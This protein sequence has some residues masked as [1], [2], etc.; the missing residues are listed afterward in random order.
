MHT[1][2]ISLGGSLIVPNG[3]IDSEFL[4]KF[5]RFI[6]GR[7]RKGDRF[8][9]IT[10]G[11][12]VAREYQNAARDVTKLTRDDLD[13]LGIHATR[14]NAH[15]LRTIFRDIAHPVICTDPTEIAASSKYKVKIAA[16]WK[17]GWSTD[18]VATRIAKRLKAELV[19]NLSNVDYVYETDPRKDKNAKKLDA[20]SWKDFR[21]I[22]G[23]KWDPGL[24]APFDPVAS[25]LAHHSG[26]P[27]VVANGK[28]IKNIGA[29]LRGGKFK[30]TKIS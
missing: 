2:V 16:G 3:H 19:I 13:W 18:Y 8:V 26:I 21:K 28:D 29:I 20:I 6:A 11:G 27:V 12:G 24:S 10:G 4:K 22:V 1:Y 5:K 23:N 30:G 14:I 9:I 17:P 25:R 7:V 15:L